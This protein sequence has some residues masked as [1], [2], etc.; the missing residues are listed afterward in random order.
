MLREFLDCDGGFWK[1]TGVSGMLRGVLELRPRMTLPH[2][3]E[4]P[5]Q[6]Q[7]KDHF[8]KVPR[9]RH[10]HP[11]E[12]QLTGIGNCL[13]QEIGEALGIPIKRRKETALEQPGDIL[14][15]E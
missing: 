7:A 2:P 12:P 8:A 9:L 1:V 4:P 13:L 10:L 14:R 11:N 3:N 5:V 15:G 6:P